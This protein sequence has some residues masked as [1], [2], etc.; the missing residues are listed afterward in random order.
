MKDVK[1]DHPEKQQNMFNNAVETVKSGG[2]ELIPK[3]SD[4]NDNLKVCLK[5]VSYG[6]IR[7]QYNDVSLKVCDSYQVLPHIDNSEFMTNDVFDQSVSLEEE[8]VNYRKR[9]SST[10]LK[11]S[12]E[13]VINEHAVLI[14]S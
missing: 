8:L 3:E 4:I 14:P 1:S 5:I 10:P 13:K 9:I 7:Y 12:E 2:E 11:T 6:Y